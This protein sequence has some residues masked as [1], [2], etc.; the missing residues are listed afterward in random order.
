MIR[1]RESAAK[2][3]VVAGDMFTDPLPRG[4]DVHLF[5]N[6][7]HDWDVDKVRPLLAASFAALT[8]GGLLLVHDAHLH[9]DKTGP[10]PVAK[11][12][13]RL[14]S[15]TEG[16]CYSLGEME[17]LLGEAGFSNVRLT[18]TVVDRSVISARK[19]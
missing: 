6:V 10:L 7:L 14:M 3:D 15:V 17:A 9:A 12:S 4:Y 2:V 16:K 18:P 13:A 5:S 1:Q 19:P 11:Y 8:S